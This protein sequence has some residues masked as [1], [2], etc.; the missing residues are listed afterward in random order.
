MNQIATP[1]TSPATTPASFISGGQCTSQITVLLGGVIQSQ[2]PARS[3]RKSARWLIEGGYDEN[4]QQSKSLQLSRRGATAFSTN[5]AKTICT[6]QDFKNPECQPDMP[7][8]SLVCHERHRMVES[9]QV[10]RPV[11]SNIV[12]CQ[13]SIS[14]LPS[15]HADDWQPE[16][17][18]PPQQRVLYPLSCPLTSSIDCRVYEIFHL[19][20]QPADTKISHRKPISQLCNDLQLFIISS[21]FSRIVY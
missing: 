14:T 11:V 3:S 7:T 15:I 6:K 21:H 8:V 20:R 10:E 17:Q 1:P 18:K 2:L 16:F 4:K 12:R 9:R 19:L 13:N 5:A